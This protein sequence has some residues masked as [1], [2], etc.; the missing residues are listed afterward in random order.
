MANI[1]DVARSAGVSHQTVSRVING[2][3]N[4]RASTRRRVLLAIQELNYRP[5][6]AARA[7]SRGRS[8]SVTVITTDTTL[9]SRVAILSGIEEAAR[10]A[11][12][13]VAVTVLDSL[14]PAAVRAAVQRASAHA[15]AGLL[16]I[17]YD[18]PGIRALRATPRGIAVAAALNVANTGDRARFPSVALDDT[19]AAG[20]ATRHLLALGHPTVHYVAEPYPPATDARR[21]GW[22]AAL[23]ATG[24]GVPE[25]VAAGWTPRSGYQAGLRLAADPGVSAVLCASDGLALGVI[26]ALHEAGLAVPDDVSVVGFDDAPQSAFYTPPLR[27]GSTTWDSAGSASPCCT[28]RASRTPRR[29]RPSPRCPS[30]SCAP[31]RA[32]S[33]GAAPGGERGTPR[34][35]S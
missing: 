24:A 2:R 28:T 8:R 7:L 27:S 14:R 10:E 32:L 6:A 5:S 33:G 17:A 22:R 26:H 4:V 19:T 3:P 20:A 29:C 31:A 15:G 21:Q 16:V 18:S 9:Y 11:G 35:A 23:R 12:F 30:S 1:H 25:V 34:R 13:T